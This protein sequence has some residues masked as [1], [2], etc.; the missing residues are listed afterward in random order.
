MG[1]GD[2]MWN[3]KFKPGII[4]VFAVC[5]LGILKISS[6]ANA[7]D[8]LN[9]NRVI[10]SAQICNHWPEYIVNITC[11]SKRLN[12]TAYNTSIEINIKS[13]VKLHSLYVSDD[14]KSFVNV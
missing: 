13:G 1:L 3:I 2:I 7:L 10:V 12:N 11:V 6:N 8:I 9:G 5:I 4:S 14:H